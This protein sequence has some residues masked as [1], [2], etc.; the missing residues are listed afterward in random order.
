MRCGSGW[1]KLPALL[2]GL[3]FLCGPAA[4]ADDSKVHFEKSRA[5]YA[6]WVKEARP[7]TLDAAVTEMRLAQKTR[8]NDAVLLQWQG[9][10]ALK[11]RKYAD[12]LEPL[13]AAIK[14]K[15]E[16]P[17]AYL[18]LA[19]AYF[20][21][22]R[23]DEAAAMYE[24]SLPV[25][26]QISARQPKTYPLRAELRHACLGLGDAQAQA[27]RWEPALAAYGRAADLDTDT[28]TEL[29]PQEIARYNDADKKLRGTDAAKIQERI[30]TAQERL[31]HGKEA[32]NAFAAALALAP[33]DF[34]LRERYATLLLTQGQTEAAVAQFAQAA[35]AR[36]AEGKAAETPASVLYRNGIALTRLARWA[37]AEP[38]FA[39]AVVQEP[40][41]PLPVRWLGYVQLQQGKNQAAYASLA[42][43]A[44]LQPNDADT[45]LNLA[46]AA[47]AL[48]RYDEAADQLEAAAKLRPNDAAIYYNLGANYGN[49]NLPAQ[50]AAAFQKALTLEPDGTSFDH[51]AA[52]AGLG[53]ALHRAGK[54]AA[55]ADAY[56]QAVQRSPNDPARW[57]DLGYARFDAAQ[58]AET[59][60]AWQAAAEALKAAL[61]HAPNDPKLRDTYALALAKAGMIQDALTQY[62]AGT[63]LEKKPLSYLL[64]LANAL[65]KAGRLS[66]AEKIT[67][68]AAQV[69]AQEHP[70]ENIPLLKHLAALQI[71]RK[72]WAAAEQTYA[73]ITAQEPREMTIYLARYH[74]LKKARQDSKASALLEAAVGIGSRV[75]LSGEQTAALTVLRRELAYRNYRTG[76]A[77]SLETARQL[78]TLALR[79]APNDANL[80]NGLGVTLLKMNRI[81]E[82]TEAL[83]KA[84]AL[85]PNYDEAVNNLGVAYES[86]NQWQDALTQYRRALHISPKNASAKQNLARLMLFLK[87]RGTQH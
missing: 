73:R 10:L 6:A 1:R 63:S 55:S 70:A 83:Q 19:F 84:I 66:E 31:G 35:A 33:D 48:H 59:P 7:E 68:R 4:R 43:A 79:D 67:M 54:F 32:G 14:R 46:R 42:K 51:A 81:R 71:K 87:Q 49:R 11:Q 78:Y 26:K 21:L 76:S 36:K 44:A 28:P 8:P 2:V 29:T 30:G 22:G 39:Q 60:A 38:L 16:L 58:S 80:H 74:L 53:I 50:S 23:S 64:E 65:E 69:Y 47:D 61:D 13:Q 57:I 41:N 72:E 20:A 9:F 62:D 86:A 40:K 15:P 25:I 75:T 24:K 85:S 52:Y 45:R 18:N 37:E 5:L 34:V 56:A 82:A 12:A 77:K 17:E 27:G 3:W